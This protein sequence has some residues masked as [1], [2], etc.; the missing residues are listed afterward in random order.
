MLLSKVHGIGAAKAR[1]LVEKHEI[2]SMEQLRERKD[3]L[4]NHH[5]LL[6]IKYVAVFN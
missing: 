3:E 4:L 2:T 5:Q 6:G 1:E